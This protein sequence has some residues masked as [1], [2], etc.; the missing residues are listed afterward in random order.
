MKYWG[1]FCGR[2]ETLYRIFS[3]D[4]PQTNAFVA[5]CFLR[6]EMARQQV[7]FREECRKIKGCGSFKEDFYTKFMTGN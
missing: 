6:G 5:F 7:A 1:I 3:V 4:K 2:S